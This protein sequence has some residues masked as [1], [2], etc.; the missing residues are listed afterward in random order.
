MT[1]LKY[2]LQKI[3]ASV[4]FLLINSKYLAILES[5][6]KLLIKHVVIIFIKEKDFSLGDNATYSS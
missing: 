4:E 6:R 1:G 3:N 5:D 2:F